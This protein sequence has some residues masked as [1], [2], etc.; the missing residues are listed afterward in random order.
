MQR[1]CS[2]CVD[3]THKGALGQGMGDA[4]LEPGIWDFDTCYETCWHDQGAISHKIFPVKREMAG[5]R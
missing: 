5:V 3:Y 4:G 1:H 2:Q